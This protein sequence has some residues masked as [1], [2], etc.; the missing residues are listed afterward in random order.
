MTSRR[1]PAIA[2]AAI[3]GVLVVAAVTI[4]PASAGDKPPAA[5]AGAREIG[6]RAS[7]ALMKQLGGA[8]MRAL[9]EGG[10]AAV[11]A[12]CADTAQALTASI[13]RDLDV[14]G[15][16]LKRT[17]LRLRNHANRPDSLEV[18]ILEAYTAALAAGDP[19]QPRLERAG[20]RYRYFAPIET[21][22]LCLQCHGPQDRL[23][24]DVPAILA[25]RYPDDEATGHAK[26]DLRGIVSVTIPAPATA[27]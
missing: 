11:V 19:V 5:A 4:A 17:S 22:G 20:D 27:P 15:L 25:E 16:E 8:L 18:A 13:A 3:L 26:G 24:G 10:P 7:Q 21:R 12:V 9:G 14:P 1:C 2:L 23:A 6:E